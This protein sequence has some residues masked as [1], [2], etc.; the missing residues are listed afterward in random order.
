MIQVLKILSDIWKNGGI[1]E[2]DKT[3]G[4]LELKNHRNIPAKTMEM[5]A[6]VF[7]QID[8]WFR[9]WESASAV[10]VT[11]QKAL[12]LSCGWQINEKLHSWLCDDTESLSMFYEWTVVLAKNGWTDIYEDFRPFQ[13]DESN[14]LANELY[15]RARAYVKKGA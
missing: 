1:I 13:T 8:E 2:R 7:P 5:A 6:Q 14:K 3:D 11:M 9:S 12:H 4:Q 15:E 10:E